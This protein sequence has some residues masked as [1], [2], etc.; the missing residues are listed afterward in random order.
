[1]EKSCPRVAYPVKRTGPGAQVVSYIKRLLVLINAND[2]LLILLM[3]NVYQ[4]FTNK[5][6]LIPNS[7]RITRRD[8]RERVSNEPL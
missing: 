3:A 5:L 4:Q 7:D 2:F 1:M 8:G 6:D